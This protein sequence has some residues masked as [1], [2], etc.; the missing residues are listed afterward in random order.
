MAPLYTILMHALRA[1][2]VQAGIPQLADI[3]DRVPAV[4]KFLFHIWFAMPTRAEATSRTT[5]PATIY[6]WA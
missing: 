5:I 3:H 6:C 2:F 4:N 1:L